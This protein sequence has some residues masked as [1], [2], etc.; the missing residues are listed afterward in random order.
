MKQR[1]LCDWCGNEISEGER[2]RFEVSRV[3]FEEG[4]N[5]RSVL[6]P[7]STVDDPVITC[8]KCREG[9]LKNKEELTSEEAEYEHRR[10]LTAPL[11][12][13][14]ILLLI[15]YVAYVVLESWIGFGRGNDHQGD[16]PKPVPRNPHPFGFNRCSFVRPHTMRLLYEARTPLTSSIVAA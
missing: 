2:L 6:D 13:I 1:W 10:K 12:L 7:A 11:Y 9:I 14:F 3:D 15:A 5:W 4:E 16:W 8:G